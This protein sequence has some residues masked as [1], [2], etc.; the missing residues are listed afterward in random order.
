[1]AIK[2]ARTSLLAA[3]IHLFPKYQHL[4]QSILSKWLPRM[5]LHALAR[6][7]ISTAGLP[8]I[9]QLKLHS[10]PH[11]L[12]ERESRRKSR[13]TAKITNADDPLDSAESFADV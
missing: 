4:H 11:G 8:V 2:Y 9:S 1:M 12:E 6:D 10:V 5:A 13:P 7:R 3:K